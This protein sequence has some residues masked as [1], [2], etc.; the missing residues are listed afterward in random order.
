MFL[1]NAVRRPF[2]GN[3]GLVCLFFRPDRQRIDVD[4]LL[5]HVCDAANGVLWVDDTQC[6]AIAGVIGLDRD[7]P[8]TVI[9]VG[10]HES[11]MIR[12]LSNPKALK[13]AV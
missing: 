7:D 11:T 6:T 9:A 8:R 5:K 12:D 2:T 4:N 1:R 10:V 13:G 3:V